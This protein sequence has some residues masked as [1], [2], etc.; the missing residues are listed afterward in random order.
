M[1]DQYCVVFD[2]S[3]SSVVNPLCPTHLFD[4]AAPIQPVRPGKHASDVQTSELLY[5]L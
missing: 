5:A 2:S 4:G 1:I 3:Q